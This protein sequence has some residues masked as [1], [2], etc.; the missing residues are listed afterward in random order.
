MHIK[1]AFTK[2]KDYLDALESRMLH[3]G[4]KEIF[5]I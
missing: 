4:I 5:S 2:R 3:E 1:M